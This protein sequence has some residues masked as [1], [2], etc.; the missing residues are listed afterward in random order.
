MCSVRGGG[1]GPGSKFRRNAVRANLPADVWDAL[2]AAP[3]RYRIQARPNNMWTEL[4]ESCSGILGRGVALAV[5]RVH[6]RPI[7]CGPSYTLVH[8]SI[9]D[10]YAEFYDVFEQ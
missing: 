1:G 2:G 5:V 4:R 7:Q 6:G 9:V 8:Q 10:C 3:H